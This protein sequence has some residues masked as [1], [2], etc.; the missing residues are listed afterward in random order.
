MLHYYVYYA[1]NPCKLGLILCSQV[2][3]WEKRKTDVKMIDV[4]TGEFDI[5]LETRQQQELQPCG[6]INHE[7]FCMDV[8]CASPGNGYCPYDQ[9]CCR[10]G[11]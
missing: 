4:S 1:Y 11:P 6:Q 5:I 9:N 7:D 8:S 2:R 10:L 3:N